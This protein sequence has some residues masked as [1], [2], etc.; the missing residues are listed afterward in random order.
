ML[1]I[2]KMKQRLIPK[3]VKR[4]NSTIQFKNK[5]ENPSPNKSIAT[6]NPINFR[7][8]SK[9]VFNLKIF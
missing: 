6:N 7:G 4:T 9:L 3:M 1:I 2:L 8:K 5:E